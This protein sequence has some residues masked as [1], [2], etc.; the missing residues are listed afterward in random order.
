MANHKTLT[1]SN[2][3]YLLAM[4]ELS[5]DLSGV[6]SKDIA[7]SLGLSKPSVHNMMDTLTD[8]GLVSKNAYGAAFLTEQ[9]IALADRYSKCYDIFYSLLSQYPGSIENLSGVVCYLLSQMTENGI[10]NMDKN[11]AHASA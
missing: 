4:R 1:A 10:D 8:M 7:A 2:I 5:S 6:K 3:R 9:G 11:G